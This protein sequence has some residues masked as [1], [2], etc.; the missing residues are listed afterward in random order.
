[1]ALRRAPFVGAPVVV[2]FL[3]RR[4]RGTVEQVDDGGRRL[5]VVTE[6]G[7]EVRFTLSPATGNFAEEG[8]AVGG[9]RLTFEEE[10]R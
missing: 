10:E 4:V 1:V 3:A 8:R 2:I 9:A 6:E 7:D 5:A